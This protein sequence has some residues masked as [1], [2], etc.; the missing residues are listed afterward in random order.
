M[1]L[2]PPTRMGRW[3]FTGLL[4]LLLAGAPPAADAETRR[5]AAT[6]PGDAALQRGGLRARP[7]R[8][9]MLS[10]V[11]SAIGDALGAR[12][13]VEHGELEEIQR[14]LL[15]TWQS[16]PKVGG[17]RVDRRSLRYIVNRDFMSQYSISI[18]GLEPMHVMKSSR[19]LA[20]AQLLSQV[21]PSRVRGILEGAGADTGFSL[22]DAV[23]MVATLRSLIRGA[24]GEVIQSM[25]DHH[26]QA[27]GGMV[28]R[29]EIRQMLETYM[30]Y[31]MVGDNTE[32]AEQL[33]DNRTL[34]EES[35]HVWESIEHFAEGRLLNFETGR[36]SKPGNREAN[37]V[38]SPMNPR[39]SLA[40]V[41][42][43]TSGITLSFGRFW[44]AD[45]LAMKDSLVKLDTAHTGR[46]RLK[47]FYGAAL[48]GEWQFSE[49]KEYLREMGALDESSA[50]HGPRV[51][52]PNYLQAISNCIVS[53]AHYRVC[54]TD[55]CDELLGE[56]EAA[57]G[58]PFGEPVEILRLVTNLTTTLEDTRP[59]IDAA[60]EAQLWQ[61]AEGHAGK[62]ALHG[63]LFAQWLHY[64][65]PRVCPFPHKAGTT[66][67][68]TP[69]EF[70]NFMA[71]FDD[72][73]E[74]LEELQRAETVAEPRG[75]AKAPDSA[76][77]GG[78]GA[79]VPSI[80]AE[81]GDTSWMTQW[82]HEEELISERPA[83][84]GWGEAGQVFAWAVLLAGLAGASLAKLRSRG[85][86]LLPTSGSPSGPSSLPL[87]AGKIHYF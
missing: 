72:M 71:T 28:S 42:E 19:D 40:D 13:G 7:G 8:E 69:M 49:S 33:L 31:W 61:I 67:S 2:R 20:E 29:E 41:Q 63:R 37:G 39:F 74:D 57:V 47:D 50:W 70:G 48:D 77:P 45:C 78:I 4:A 1:P 36:L 73:E 21:A 25:Y 15:P 65:F 76:A 83:R 87:H 54:C 43:I 24:D 79:T 27:T 44:M 68:Q 14:R 84:A 10:E 38:Y 32:G 82:S 60:M 22:Q 30:V 46:V 26:H 81:D 34:L 85:A 18:K 66:T 59:R 51:V 53:A 52:I 6:K 9:Q 17:D 58:A 64:A 23:G 55:E 80:L 86:T 56:V 75:L 11:L 12:H 35:F 5:V 16:L 62:V 3:A